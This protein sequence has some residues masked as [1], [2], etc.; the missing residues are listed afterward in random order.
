[1]KR[2]EMLNAIEK[3]LTYSTHQERQ[4]RNLLA[5]DI[6]FGIE[7]LGMLPPT[8]TTKKLVEIPTSVSSEGELCYEYG[9]EEFQVNEWEKE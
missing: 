2:S 1:M 3:I 9:H 4:H 8:V 7:S 6:L 5:Q